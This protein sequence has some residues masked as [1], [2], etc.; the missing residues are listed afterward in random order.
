LRGREDADGLI[1]TDRTGRHAGAP[2][3][4]GDSHADEA[5]P[6]SRSNVKRALRML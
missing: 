5:K 4:L 2:G 6:S 1:E 3:Q